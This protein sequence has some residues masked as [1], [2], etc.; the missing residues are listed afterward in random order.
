MIKNFVFDLD[1]TLLD[2]IKEITR[3]LNDTLFD[4]HL[5]TITVAEGKSFLGHGTE[6]LLSHAL[7]G[8]VLDAAPYQRFK[9]AYMERQIAYQ[10][11]DTKPFHGVS[12][13][14]EGLRQRKAR[15]FVYSN[16]PHDFAVKLIDAIFPGVFLAV[17]GQKPGCAPKP[18]VEP[19]LPYLEAFSV[20]PKASVYIG[21]SLV[22][23]ETA[24]AL[25]MRA[26][27]VAWGYVPRERLVEG[28]PDFLI[29]EPRQLLSLAFQDE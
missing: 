13:L 24:R 15:L 18:N 5:P 2:T 14:L 3:A 7:K 12:S 20:D 17:V 11:E 21:D 16:K 1:G 26:I 10:L 9:A 29:D 19:F 6:Y 22:D 28:R 23:V 27:S 25:K 8:A 4:F